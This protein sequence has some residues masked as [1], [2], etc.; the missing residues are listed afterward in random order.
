[1]QPAVLD[2]S[3]YISAF[4]RRDPTVFALRQ[5][6]LEDPLWLS[7]VVLEELYAGASERA[8]YAIES[9]ERE[10]DRMS[11]ILLPNLSDWTLAGKMLYQ[12][13][14]KYK[15][16]QIGRTRLTNDAL[17]AASAARTGTLVITL[18]SRDLE[19]LAEFCPFQWQI[20]SF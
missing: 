8:A 5:W 1:M 16:E 12:L 14:A 17:L 4:R 20:F 11:R 19:R 10:F 15:Y 7:A 3:V 13:A 18:N 6:D 2:S 9:L